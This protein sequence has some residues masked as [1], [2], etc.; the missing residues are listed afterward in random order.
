MVVAH[1]LPEVIHGGE[2]LD[3]KYGTAGPEAGQ[4][5]LE[6]LPRHGCM[7]KDRA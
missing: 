6:R 3:S 1:V 5:V 4:R 2:G 7:D